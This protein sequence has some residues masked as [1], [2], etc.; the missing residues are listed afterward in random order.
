MRTAVDIDGPDNA[1]IAEFAD[2]FTVELSNE[3]PQECFPM[4]LVQSNGKV[5]KSSGRFD[6][7]AAMRHKTP[8]LCTM[9]QLA[10]LFFYRWEVAGTLFHLR[11]SGGIPNACPARRFSGNYPTRPSWIGTNRVHDETNLNSIKKTHA[12]RAVPTMRASTITRSDER[13]TG[14]RTRCPTIMYLLRNIPGHFVRAMAGFS[15]HHEGNYYIPRARI[16]PPEGLRRSLWPWVDNWFDGMQERHSFS[17][18]YVRPAVYVM[19]RLTR[20]HQRD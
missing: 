13:G 17:W 15:S 8:L 6:Y 18:E 7:I 19:A 20:Y 2:L 3:G 5:N 14:R 1:G 4:V 12:G 11:H 10:F 16:A 9:S